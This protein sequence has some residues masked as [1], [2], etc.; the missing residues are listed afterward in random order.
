ML[1]L[2][3]QRKL[4][5]GSGPAAGEVFD[6][7]RPEMTVGRSPDSDIHVPDR[8]VSHSH[9]VLRSVGD[10]TDLSDLGSHNG[11]FVNGL[12]VREHVLA[13]GDQIIVGQVAFLFRTLGAGETIE[14]PAPNRTSRLS[15]TEV[16]PGVP[17]ARETLALLCVREIIRSVQ[18]V[19]FVGF[20]GT[21]PEAEVEGLFDWIVRL[22]PSR[23]G[24]L[25][26][27]DASGELSNLSAHREVVSLP[28]AVLP[29][30]LVHEM[31]SGSGAMT[32]DQMNAPWIASPVRVS[33]KLLGILYLDSYGT[34]RDYSQNDLDMI[35]ALAEVLG[36]AL[37]NARDIEIL[38]SE[39]ARLNSET[40]LEDGLVGRSA[41]IKNLNSTIA[42][43]ARGNSTVLIR[44]ESGTG[45]ELVAR[46]IHRN[47]TRAAKPFVAINC[48]AI[49]ETLLESELF[50][51]EKGAFT[52]AVAQRKGRFEVADGGTVF[53]DEVGELAAALQAKLLRVLQEREFERVGGTKP[54]HI[55]IRLIAATNRDLEK[56]IHDG[57]FREDLFYRLNVLPIHT[58]ALRDRPEDIPVLGEFFVRRF[59]GQLGR[60]VRGI[61]K[62]ARMYLMAYKW[63]GNVRE[64]QNILE[65]AVVLGTSE[66]IVPDDLPAEL[67]DSHSAEDSKAEG[68]HARMRELRRREIATALDGAN[69]NVAEAAR[70]LKLH[71][72][73]L[74]RLITNLGLRNTGT[75]SS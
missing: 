24:I 28:Q 48:A 7:D 72:V 66:W 61:S 26:M 13:D 1:G 52:G 62:E 75:T 27:I 55:D 34:A 46:A 38:R 74:H 44:G 73:Y 12:R 18:S 40:G 67:L 14:A 33:G 71:P 57:T 19:Y 41:A 10:R 20:D 16:E 42:K 17:M 36:L 59:R 39:N 8:S 49:A 25:A 37:E 45:K 50:G 4:I 51:N 65:R 22:V 58:P 68:F 35:A 43:V 30:S 31:I 60:D 2:F 54:V 53:L 15:Q 70:N 23:R 6:I 5:V 32:G 69:G 47:G 29:D 9:C 63:P 56:A 11:T 3:M 64:L 21:K